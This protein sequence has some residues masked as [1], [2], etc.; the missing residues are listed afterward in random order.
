MAGN[1]HTNVR[2]GS[3]KKTNTN[4]TLLAEAP[5]N[6][7]DLW[8]HYWKS[9]VFLMKPSLAK[10]RRG[11]KEKEDLG[12]D[13]AVETFLDDEEMNRRVTDWGSENEHRERSLSSASS[14]RDV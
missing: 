3:A 13:G 8:V 6:R 10:T 1:T 14:V 7:I 2:R 12:G 5:V 11:G 4:H 9:F